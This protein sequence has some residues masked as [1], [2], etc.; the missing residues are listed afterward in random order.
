[1]NEEN[2]LVL[3][4]HKHLHDSQVHRHAFLCMLIDFHVSNYVLLETAY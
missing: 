4:K 1:M 3:L 2:L